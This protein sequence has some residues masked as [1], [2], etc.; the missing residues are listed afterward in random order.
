MTPRGVEIFDAEW[1][2]CNNNIIG[3]FPTILQCIE[4]FKVGCAK[5]LYTFIIQDHFCDIRY[6]RPAPIGPWTS[7]TRTTVIY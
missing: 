3:R 5:T 1:V 4:G 6:P 7:V 2:P